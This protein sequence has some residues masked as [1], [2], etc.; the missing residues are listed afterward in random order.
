MSKKNFNLD[1]KS[2]TNTGAIKKMVSANRGR[3][4]ATHN[5]ERKTTMVDPVLWKKMKLIATKEDRQF[6]D[7]FNDAIDNYVNSYEKKNG[8]VK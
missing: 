8:E 4:K 3:P 2:T 6:H 5:R 1:S 7:L